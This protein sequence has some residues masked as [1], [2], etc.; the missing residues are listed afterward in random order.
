[1]FSEVLRAS[2]DSTRLN[3]SLVGVLLS[4]RLPLHIQNE[5]EH[6]VLLHV[7]DSDSIQG[8]AYQVLHVMR[9]SILHVKEVCVPTMVDHVSHVTV[10]IER[11]RQTSLEM[12][13]S[14]AYYDSRFVYHKVS[15]IFL[16]RRYPV[17][18]FASNHALKAS[19][20]VAVEVLRAEMV[21]GS[22]D[23]LRDLCSYEERRMQGEDSGVVELKLGW[24]AVSFRGQD[25]TLSELQC[26]PRISFYFYNIN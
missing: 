14:E 16:R 12:M 8:L 19:I 24:E 17:R 7:R 13:A 22:E 10:E 6:A 3:L 25:S 21:E 26:C 20:L 5:I 4:R 9:N 2:K 15:R 23:G 11:S 1:M 18:V